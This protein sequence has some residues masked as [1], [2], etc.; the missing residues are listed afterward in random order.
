M[1]LIIFSAEKYIFDCV[2]LSINCSKHDPSWETLTYFGNISKIPI[3]THVTILD[4]LE[5]Y[6]PSSWDPVTNCY[7]CSEKEQNISLK[8]KGQIYSRRPNVCAVA[9]CQNDNHNLSFPTVKS[10]SKYGTVIKRLKTFSD[11]MCGLL[12]CAHKMFSATLCISR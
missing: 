5:Y 7:A 11:L 10:F 8:T 4:K 1:F 6:I 2:K 3:P 12:A 9:V